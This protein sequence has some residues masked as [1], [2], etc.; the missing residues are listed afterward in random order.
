MKKVALFVIFALMS[1]GVSAQ[2]QLR[3]GAHLG[4]PIGDAGDIATFSIALDLAYLFEISE[5]MEN[6]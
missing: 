4:L 3:G 2:G 1:I 5:K 6:Y